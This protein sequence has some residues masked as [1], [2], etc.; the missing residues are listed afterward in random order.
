MKLSAQTHHPTTFQYSCRSASWAWEGGVECMTG[1][2]LLCLCTQRL[3]ECRVKI[4]LVG[5]GD[6]LSRVTQG[7]SCCVHSKE[8]KVVAKLSGKCPR[9]T[10]LAPA[11]GRIRMSFLL[12]LEQLLTYLLLLEVWILLPPL[13]SSETQQCH[14][15][16]LSLT[17][18]DSF[19]CWSVGVP[20]TAILQGKNFY[21]SQAD[22]LIMGV[23]GEGSGPQLQQRESFIGLSWSLQASKA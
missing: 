18:I 21:Y 19:F 22:L 16:W 5:L 20:E 3:R 17:F 1:G 13:K 8:S 9:L 11:P 15:V 2:R 12:L 14:H 6:R 7:N 10:V 4:L 23:G